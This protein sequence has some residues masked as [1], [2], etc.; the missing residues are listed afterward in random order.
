[1]CHVELDNGKK[2]PRKRHFKNRWEHHHFHLL[3]FLKY[4]T[5]ELELA[6][7][8]WQTNNRTAQGVSD[9]H[10]KYEKSTQKSVH[11]RGNYSESRNKAQKQM[12]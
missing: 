3:T 1:M 9:I 8:V 2:L 6:R 10:N 5:E 11:S 12:P 4:P 7:I